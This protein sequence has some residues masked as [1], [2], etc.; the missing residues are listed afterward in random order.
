MSRLCA[1]TWGPSVRRSKLL[2]SAVVRPIMTYGVQIWAV[3]ADG[4]MITPSRIKQ[5]GTVQN[6][7]LR[8]IMGAYKR[9]PTAALEKESGTP[10][11]DL[12]MENLAVQRAGVTAQ[13]RVTEDIE[14]NIKGIWTAA[15]KVRGVR[16]RGRPALQL[17]KP[18][19]G[20]SR[21]RTRAR[22]ITEERA[23]TGKT[24]AYRRALTDLWKRRWQQESIKTGRSATTWLDD[25]TEHR[26]GCTTTFQSMKQQRSSSS[27]R[28][29]SD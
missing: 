3:Q 27:V 11:I 5:L 21:L 23:I 1:S 15:R 20:F 28:R 24:T 4:S 16:R 12:Y 22:G 7:C 2:Y 26:S 10:P 25:W 19:T 29:Y 14:E 17:E 6:K 8:K 9:T 13:H 18:P